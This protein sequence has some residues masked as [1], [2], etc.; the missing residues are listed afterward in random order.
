M[1]YVIEGIGALVNEAGEEQP[2]KAQEGL[3]PLTSK[4]MTIPNLLEESTSDSDQS[5]AS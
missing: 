3:L 4:K 5:P 2:L 1:I